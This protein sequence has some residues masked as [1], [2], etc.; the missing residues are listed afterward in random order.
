MRTATWGATPDYERVPGL[1]V[2]RLEAPFFYANAAPVVD[3][4][5]RLVGSGDPPPAAVILDFGANSDLDITSSEKL[6]ELATALRAVGIEFAL[7]EM[8]RPVR[9]DAR[10]SGVLE[11]IG[12]NRV[13]LTIDEAVSAL[14]PAPA[15]SP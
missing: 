7:A 10:R 13:Y 14:G 6:G 4:V 3:A 15:A 8:R 5:K 12:E 11:T 2:L 1:L 9:E